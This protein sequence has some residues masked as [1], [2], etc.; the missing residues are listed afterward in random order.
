MASHTHYL[1]IDLEATCCDDD[2]F[3]RDQMEIIEIG[4][5]LVEAASL[6][7]V[8]EFQ[9]F[10]RP[11]RHRQLTEFCT[12]L[13]SITQAQVDAAPRFSVAIAGLRELVRGCEPLFCSWGQYD[14][15]QL[16]R[17]ARRHGVSLPLGRSHLNLKERFARQLGES[18][19][20]GVGQALRRLGLS[21]EGTQHRAIDD[22]RNIARILPYAL[23]VRA[24]ERRGADR[25]RA[26][27]R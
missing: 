24:P 27:A 4:A 19:S 7:P 21:F 12:R 13:T 18:R 25:S 22:A 8:R 11:T 10:V 5:L 1:V 9:T 23:G 14:R 17:D 6:A 26:S 2:S 3:P 15:N 16:E 20:F